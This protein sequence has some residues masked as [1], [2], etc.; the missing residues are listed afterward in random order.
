ML[1]FFFSNRKRRLI[2]HYQIKFIFKIH[3][4]QF[5]TKR[6]KFQNLQF[7]GSIKEISPQSIMILFAVVDLHSLNFLRFHAVFSSFGEIIDWYPPSSWRFPLGSPETSAVL[8][9][10]L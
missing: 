2:S 4:N 7:T 6:I 5:R 9:Y 3:T 8:R 1:K 10:L